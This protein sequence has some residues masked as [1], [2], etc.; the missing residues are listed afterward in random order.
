M[1][2]AGKLPDHVTRY[3]HKYES[4]WMMVPAPSRGIS[5]DGIITA[6]GFAMACAGLI[7]AAVFI[8][9]AV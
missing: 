1:H 7:V 6:L 5:F 9:R 3:N 4:R 8:L 2:A